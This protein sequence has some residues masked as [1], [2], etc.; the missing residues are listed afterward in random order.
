MT[1]CK[2]DWR[3]VLEPIEDM[4][5]VVVGGYFTAYSES[6]DEYDTPQIM[7]DLVNELRAEIDALKSQSCATCRHDSSCVVQQALLKTDIDARAFCCN[8]WEASEEGT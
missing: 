2:N 8:G 7:N 6:R 5:G 1:H 3:I 4:A